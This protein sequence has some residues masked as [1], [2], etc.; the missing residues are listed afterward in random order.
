V[1]DYAYRQSPIIDIE[2]DWT[3][4]DLER[5]KIGGR[6]AMDRVCRNAD[7]ANSIADFLILGSFRRG[8][9]EIHPSVLLIQ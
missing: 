5:A 1:R 3:M 2:K 4:L 6:F 9:R 7:I 8:R